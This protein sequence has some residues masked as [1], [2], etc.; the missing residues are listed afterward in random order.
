MS[1]LRHW[2]TLETDIGALP[3]HVRFT[4][5]SRTLVEPIGMSVLCQKRTH[6]LQQNPSLF[7]RIVGEQE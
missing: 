2:Q 7:D 1:V 6:A 5:K 3:G 4:P